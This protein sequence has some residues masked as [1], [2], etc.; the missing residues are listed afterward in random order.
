MKKSSIILFF[1]ILTSISCLTSRDNNG[2]KNFI[3][4]KG[5]RLRDGDQ[6]FRFI[7]FNI[8][9]LLAIEDNMPFTERNAWRL[10]NAFEIED[11]LKTIKL[12]GG[13]V[14]RTY[15]ITVKRKIDG[16]EI[17]KYVEGPGK[18]NERAFQTMDS[19]LAI[20]NKVGVRLLIP[21][22]DNWKWMG[23]VP[24]YAEF[25]GKSQESF[26][27]DVQIKADFKKTISFILNRK[28]TITGIPYK[29]DK[30]ILAWELGN[31]LRD[32]PMDWI[33]EMAAYVKSIDANHLVNDG[34]QSSHIPV[35]LLNIPEIDILS[36][37][38]YEN[39]PDDMIAH[40]R[41]NATIIKGKKPYYI[42]EFGFISTTGI[43]EVLDLVQ[44]N[45]NI[46]GALIW[47]LRFH[48]R[49]G[50]FYWHSEPM[51][52]GLYKAYHWPG[53]LSG[54]SYDEINLLKLYE[55][56]A[57]QI[58]NLKIKAPVIPDVPKL[59]PVSD[60]SKISW[61]GSVGAEA[62]QVE[63]A[64]NKPGPW[65]IVGENVSDAAVAYAPLFNDL[66]A[67]IGKSYFYRVKAKNSAGISE[68][69]PV[70]GPVKV[71]RKTL[72]DEMQNFA[73]LYHREGKLTIEN[74][75]TR[76][77]KEDFHRICGE[78]GSEIIYYVPENITAFRIDS[79]SKSEEKMFNISV[80]SDGK[81]YKN[82]EVNQTNYFAGKAD[83][84]YW[85]PILLE[86]KAIPGK[87]Q[88]L[89][90][91]YNVPAQVGRVEISYAN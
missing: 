47:S 6:E 39:N 88:Y 83:Y 54:N 24:Q 72:V 75:S 74:G 1:I 12:M 7:S 52:G 82:V 51:G 22:V 56:R 41:E 23:G 71:T 42:G 4:A 40:I 69:S 68:P 91:E 19:V 73:V 35:E 30:A 86:G 76:S 79:F 62:Y 64:E 8:P 80:S 3:T 9:N 14:A 38:H 44:Q 78:K 26:W 67:E 60:I 46:S 77:F 11:A 31:E 55:E 29:A 45:E 61:Q 43:R 2:F 66:T 48:N 84:D 13:S 81:N 16:P 20:A 33:A 57:A 15:V 63:R 58:Q 34:I 32:V 49:D 50:G 21:F 65:Q 89:K 17:I 37:H 90:I 85:Q 27:T 25:R 87:M 53:F 10:P 36:T 18:F 70:V 28:N 59:L 5:D